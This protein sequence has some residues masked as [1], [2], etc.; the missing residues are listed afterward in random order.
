ML[1]LD[2]VKVLIVARL[3]VADLEQDV[4]VEIQAAPSW[5]DIAEILGSLGFDPDEALDFIL[6]SI[7]SK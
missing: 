2:Q 6:D 1:T 7:I 3:A 4:S 5:Q